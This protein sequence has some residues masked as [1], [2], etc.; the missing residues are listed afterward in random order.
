M[1]VEGRSLVS[2]LAPHMIGIVCVCAVSVI[3][4]VCMLT[5]FDSSMFVEVW[6]CACVSF[7]RY[8]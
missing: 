6:V 4:F 3:G 8:A 5:V 7:E 1:K 2:V